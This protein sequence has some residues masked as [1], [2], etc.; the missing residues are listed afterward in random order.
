MNVGLYI[1][2]NVGLAGAKIQR[3]GIAFVP[4]ATA[5]EVCTYCD[6]VQCNLQRA[7]ESYCLQ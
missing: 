1:Y 2:M 4:Q 7:H 5:P 3:R 6:K